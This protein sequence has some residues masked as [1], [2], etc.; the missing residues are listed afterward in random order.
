M[1]GNAK[2]APPRANGG[3]G[4]RD[5][6]ASHVEHQLRI[7]EGDVCRGPSEGFK[8]TEIV[9]ASICGLNIGTP[10]PTMLRIDSY[11]AAQSGAYYIDIN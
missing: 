11:R 5:G 7:E 4:T 10:F 2:P 1:D 9:S 8:L 6:W 3:H